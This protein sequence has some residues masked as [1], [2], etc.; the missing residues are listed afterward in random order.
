MGCWVYLMI[1]ILTLISYFSHWRMLSDSTSFL[2]LLLLLLSLDMLFV[3]SNIG[4]CNHDLLSLLCC[5]GG[6]GMGYPAGFCDS[7]FDAFFADY[8]IFKLLLRNQEGHPRY[9]A[10]VH[11]HWRSKASKECVKIKSSL[12]PRFQSF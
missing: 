9:R 4:G 6:L 1:T 7:Q 11:Q 8:F 5:L 3:T 12:V 10:Q 2:L